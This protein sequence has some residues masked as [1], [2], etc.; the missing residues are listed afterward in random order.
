[1]VHA[2]GKQLYDACAKRGA[3]VVRAADVKRIAKV[4]AFESLV[5][6][7][8]KAMP[9]PAAAAKSLRRVVAKLHRKRGGVVMRN[10]LPADSLKQSWRATV[11]LEQALNAAAEHG[12]LVEIQNLLVDGEEGVQVTVPQDSL[13]VFGDQQTQTAAKQTF[14]RSKITDARFPMLRVSGDKSGYS[15]DLP[16]AWLEEN[17]LAAAGCAPSTRARIRTSTARSGLSEIVRGF[18][19]F[20]ARDINERRQTRGAG[21]ELRLNRCTSFHES[22]SQK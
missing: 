16:Q 15:L 19:T 21:G 10:L 14:A 5:A 7:T 2:F 3:P 4:G 13:A 9:I 17:P 22:I 1:M 18:K 12:P 8:L 6:G 11:S 20:S